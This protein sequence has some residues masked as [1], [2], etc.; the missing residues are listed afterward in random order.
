[1]TARPILFSNTAERLCN[2]SINQYGLSRVN[3]LTW[4][5]DHSCRGIKVF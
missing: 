5:C 1:M 3:F 2:F 4:Y